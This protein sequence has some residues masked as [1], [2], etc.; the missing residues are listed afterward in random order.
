MNYYCFTGNISNYFQYRFKAQEV[1][2]KEGVHWH[3]NFHQVTWSATIV[4]AY[5]TI[6]PSGL[7]GAL[8]SNTPKDSQ[9]K[10][11]WIELVCIFG[12]CLAPFVPASVLW[13]IQISLG[14]KHALKKDMPS[15]FYIL[16]AF[17]EKTM[18]NQLSWL[19]LDRVLPQLNILLFPSSA[20]ARCLGQF[21][22][23]WWS[24]GFSYL[25]HC[26]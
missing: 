1:P 15:L 5:A 12:Y 18:K 22:H 4:F 6:V 3:Y 19:L 8:W 16:A 26:Q 21:C 23:F 10:P 17:V 9:F 11:S 13:L 25:A 24:F 2:A 14:K 20:M 7:F